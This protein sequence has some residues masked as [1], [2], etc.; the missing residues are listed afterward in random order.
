MR[1]Q[2]GYDADTLLLATVVVLRP[3]KGVEFLLQALARLASRESAARARL[4]VVGDGSERA[5]LER[6]AAALGLGERVRFLGTRG[7]VAALLAASDAYVQPSLF[8]ALPTSV[9]EAMAVGVPVVATAVGGTL[10]LVQPGVNGL[11]VPP[12]DPAA[13]AEAL[14][15]LLDA[16][17]ADRARMGQ[18][19]RDWVLSHASL[20]VWLDNLERIYRQ[21]VAARD[22]G[23]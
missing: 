5:D 22:G 4:L 1:R 20:D 18:A 11:L 17:A 19:G 21:V 6:Q 3:G 7:D 16:S 13:L 2:L 23:S 8:E 10:E 15:T 9:L 14:A 12:S